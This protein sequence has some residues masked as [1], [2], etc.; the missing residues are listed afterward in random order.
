MRRLIQR[1]GRAATR[2]SDFAYYMRRG[3]SI[4]YAWRQSGRVIH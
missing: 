4:S 2:L 3:H 1:A